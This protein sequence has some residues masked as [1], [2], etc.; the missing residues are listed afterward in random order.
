MFTFFGTNIKSSRKYLN[1]INLFCL[2]FMN[3]KDGGGPPPTVAEQPAATLLVEEE[4][5]KA[6]VQP[7]ARWGR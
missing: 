6:D 4:L 5:V 2:Q 7:T 1:N 3:K